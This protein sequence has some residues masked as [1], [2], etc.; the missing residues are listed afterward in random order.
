MALKILVTGSNGLLGQKLVHKLAQDPEVD[1]IAISRGV[2]R[3]KVKENY[4][5]FPV[6]ITDKPALKQLIEWLQPSVIINTAALTNVDACETERD[7]CWKVNVTAVETLAKLSRKHN[8]HLIHLSTDFVFDGKNGPYK[9]DDKPNPLSYYGHSKWESEK[10]IEQI[11]PENWSILRT[12]IVYGVIDD[13]SRSNLILWAKNALTKGD[14]IKVVD[15]QF[16][17]PTLAEDLADACI[18]TAKRKAK[19]YFH[20][21]GPETFSVLEIVKQVA[22]FYQLDKSKIT[23]VKSSTLG[24]PAARPPRTGFDISKA[25]NILGYNPKTLLQGIEIVE[26]QLK[27]KK[28]PVLN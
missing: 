22:D 2:N 15:D 9:E 26:Q 10:V 4:Q 23:P 12:I 11:N 19:G 3:C 1:L 8:V 13:A 27:E 16:R 14:P 20:I 6:D 28:N 7:A 18:Q 17:A 5:Y 24:Q 21:S 25:R